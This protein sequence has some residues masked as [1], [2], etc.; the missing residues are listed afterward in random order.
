MK[1]LDGIA[2]ITLLAGGVAAILWGIL[3][4]ATSHLLM[5]PRVGWACYSLAIFSVILMILSWR[6]R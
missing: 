1:N 2:I 5:M 4:R 3:G 6:S